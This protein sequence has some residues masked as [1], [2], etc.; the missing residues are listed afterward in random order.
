[1]FNRDKGESTEYVTRTEAGEY[2]AAIAVDLAS[3]GQ[4]LARLEEL[5]R[6]LRTGSQMAQ[7]AQVAAAPSVPSDALT[8]RDAS[9]ALDGLKSEG[10]AQFRQTRDEIAELSAYLGRKI[11][12]AARAV[13][14]Q[15]SATD[16]VRA[17]DNGVRL[18]QDVDYGAV[19]FGL[20]EIAAKV[21]GQIGAPQELVDY[22]RESVQ[23][24]ADVF[25]KS[26]SAFDEAEFKRQ[27][28]A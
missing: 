13:I 2:R 26:N 12:D 14:G 8:L 27:A 9:V 15:A 4:R 5:A 7:E 22:Y 16:A 23:F 21:R 17:D 18:T 1:M 10:L 20:S 6:Q 3:V 28:G 19:A 24:F 11:D 25:A